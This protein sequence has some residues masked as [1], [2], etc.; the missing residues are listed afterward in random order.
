MLENEL[1]NHIH[2]IS[3]LLTILVVIYM[4]LTCLVIE[5]LINVLMKDIQKLNEV[6]SNLE[7]FLK[8]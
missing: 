3:K 5:F 6:F 8:Y 4:L 2:R 1:K 7:I